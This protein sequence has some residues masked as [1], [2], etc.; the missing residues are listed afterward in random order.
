[1]AIHNPVKGFVVV[2]VAR[3]F[4]CSKE[5]VENNYIYSSISFVVTLAVTLA[6]VIVI[7]KMLELTRKPTYK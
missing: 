3:V 2:I 7:R 4:H 6:A 1:M 5:I